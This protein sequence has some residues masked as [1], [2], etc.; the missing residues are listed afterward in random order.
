M[1]RTP[2]P[3]QAQHLPQS[4]L[5]APRGFHFSWSPP[6]PFS[7]LSLQTFHL[8][9][10]FTFCTLSTWLS[11]L[12]LHRPKVPLDHGSHGWLTFTEVWGK[13]KPVT[14]QQEITSNSHQILLSLE[15]YW[16]FS[17]I[18]GLF[19]RDVSSWTLSP[20]MFLG[21]SAL[22]IDHIMSSLFPLYLNCS[23]PHSSSP[24]NSKCLLL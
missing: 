21:P 5:R 8:I 23:L 24:E 18:W 6:T 4:H 2:K 14:T 15:S 7:C 9:G 22:S 12:F 1:L 17:T 19:I 16:P 11:P 20:A 10:H 13:W 3:R